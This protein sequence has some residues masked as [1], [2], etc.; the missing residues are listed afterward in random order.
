MIEDLPLDV[1]ALVL[2]H[3]VKD[4]DDSEDS[5]KHSIVSRLGKVAVVNRILYERVLG[6]NEHV[7]MV[8]ARALYPRGVVSVEEG[9]QSF[10]ELV[11]DD[12]RRG[13]PVV[14]WVSGDKWYD[15][16]RG[17]RWSWSTTSDHDNEELL[18]TMSRYGW[19]PLHSTTLLRVDVMEVGRGWMYGGCQYLNVGVHMEYSEGVSLSEIPRDVYV[20]LVQEDVYTGAPSATCGCVVRD[21]YR[22]RLYPPWVWNRDNKN[23]S[24]SVKDK[25]DVWLCDGRARDALD[26]SLFGLHRVCGLFRC[27]SIDD[28]RRGDSWCACTLRFGNIMNELYEKYA[29]VEHCG[30][31]LM[32]G[33]QEFMYPCRLGPLEQ[34]LTQGC[35]KRICSTDSRIMHEWKPRVI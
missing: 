25:R 23:S 7:W 33:S 34:L 18:L 1:L 6:S 10:K 11:R 8:L 32:F 31:Y 30:I 3:L 4:T 19:R 20:A 14:C 2:L 9:Y 17:E 24:L 28:V 29:S 15:S 12:N 21:L 26:A 16:S 22:K 35:C 5:L 13:C 27:L